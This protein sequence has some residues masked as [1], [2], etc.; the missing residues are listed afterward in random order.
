M[1]VRI[2]E[3]AKC[4]AIS[5]PDKELTAEHVITW[6]LDMDDA[7]NAVWNERIDKDFFR[8]VFIRGVSQD[9]AAQQPPVCGGEFGYE[10][11]DINP[12]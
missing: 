12:K 3:G 11:P 8:C 6:K 4:L 10:R 9:P 7:T 2:F 1:S 5:A